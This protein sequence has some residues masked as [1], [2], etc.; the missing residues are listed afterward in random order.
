[1][2]AAIDE[3]VVGMVANNE[4]LIKETA[5]LSSSCSHGS[6]L[7]GLQSSLGSLGGLVDG[8]LVGGSGKAKLREGVVDRLAKQQS[9]EEFLQDLDATLV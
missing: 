5:S 8:G 1:M 2:R 4:L 7:R 6:S 9:M 3:A